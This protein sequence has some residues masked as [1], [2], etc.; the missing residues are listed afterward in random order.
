MASAAADASP[1]AGGIGDPSPIGGRKNLGRRGGGG[2]RRD[3]SKFSGEAAF[4]DLGLWTSAG[5]RKFEDAVVERDQSGAQFCLEI[6]SDYV[7]KLLENSC[8]VLKS[9]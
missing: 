8:L 1:A 7:V 3:I 4:D 9:K 2:C 6:I 5:A